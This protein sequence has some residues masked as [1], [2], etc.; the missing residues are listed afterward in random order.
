MS[1]NVRDVR[2]DRHDRDLPD[3]ESG[4]EVKVTCPRCGAWRRVPPDALMLT[5]PRCPVCGEV[6]R[7]EP[8]DHPP[9]PPADPPPADATNLTKP[10]PRLSS[11]LPDGVACQCG[12]RLRSVGREYL[13]DRCQRPLPAACQHCYRVL[14]VVAEGRAVCATCQVAYAFQ[15]ERW[16]EVTTD[17]L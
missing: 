1:A 9:T 16:R 17:A 8:K 2:D 5:D 14:F 11:R 10:V 4:L 6:M 12:G 3:P 15:D 7:P 13:C